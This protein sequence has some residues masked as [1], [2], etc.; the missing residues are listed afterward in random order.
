MKVRLDFATGTRRFVLSFV[1]ELGVLYANKSKM[2]YRIRA[3]DNGID[4]LNELFNA[5]T[6]VL[7]DITHV[8]NSEQTLC[9]RHRPATQRGQRNLHGKLRTSGVLGNRMDHG[10]KVKTRDGKL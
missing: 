9:A 6:W 5:K 4:S 1:L 7:H 2:N 8:A 3:L 10:M